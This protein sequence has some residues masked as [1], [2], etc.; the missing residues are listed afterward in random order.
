VS[1]YYYLI[2]RRPDGTFD[3]LIP[4]EAEPVV[5]EGE[6]VGYKLRHN[7]VLEGGPGDGLLMDLRAETL[8]WDSPWRSYEPGEY[9]QTDRTDSYGRAIYDWT[10][11]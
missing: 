5:E 4:I 10:P 6:I 8:V 9:R 3:H 7:A 1:D 2:H 11:A